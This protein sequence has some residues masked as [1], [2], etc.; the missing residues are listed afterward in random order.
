VHKFKGLAEKMWY[1]KAVCWHL[2]LDVK[3]LKPE[4][5]TRMSDQY[6]AMMGVI[7]ELIIE[8]SKELHSLSVHSLN[9]KR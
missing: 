4:A 1:A 5:F 8:K 6:A 7:F 9:S 2:N 3:R